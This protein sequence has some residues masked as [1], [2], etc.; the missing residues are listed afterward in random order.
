MSKGEEKSDALVLGEL[1]EAEADL[2]NEL[3]ALREQEALARKVRH[4]AEAEFRR[5]SAELTNPLL[6]GEPEK[7]AA[8]VAV[9]L[10]E[11]RASLDAQ[12]QGH[13]A[14]LRLIQEKERE[15]DRN[16]VRQERTIAILTQRQN[17]RLQRF[18]MVWT[19][20]IA[21]ATI[22]SLFKPG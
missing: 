17:L 1:G 13:E 3:R 10:A 9:S 15:I 6:N 18:L 7:Q 2:N 5:G 11:L 20:I 8:Y 22:A 12:V 4:D 21:L 14:A 16:Q 19:A